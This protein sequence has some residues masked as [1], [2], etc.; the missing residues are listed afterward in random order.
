MIFGATF[1]SV[2]SIHPNGRT[3]GKLMILFIGDDDDDDDDGV[4]IK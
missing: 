4:C 1:I 3:V 2:L